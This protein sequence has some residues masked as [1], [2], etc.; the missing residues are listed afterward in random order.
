MLG[1]MHAYSRASSGYTSRML[2]I[3]HPVLGTL[4]MAERAAVLS[5]RCAGACPASMRRLAVASHRAGPAG[6]TTSG[7]T[8]V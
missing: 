5:P 8:R 7:M 4:N 3:S 1:N 6:R 2:Q